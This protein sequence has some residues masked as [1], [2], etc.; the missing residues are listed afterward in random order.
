M[1]RMKRKDVLTAIRA[2]GYHGDRERAML[3]Y[4]KNWVSFRVYAREFEAGVA[5]RHNG[6]PCDCFECKKGEPHGPRQAF[7]LECTSRSES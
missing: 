5:M 3:L 2:A 4:V 1:I 6:V 7:G